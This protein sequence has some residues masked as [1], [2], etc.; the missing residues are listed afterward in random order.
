[1]KNLMLSD[2]DNKSESNSWRKS[3]VFRMPWTSDS[4]STIIRNKLS[5]GKRNKTAILMMIKLSF[6]DHTYIYTS[7]L[8]IREYWIA[9]AKEE[10]ESLAVTTPDLIIP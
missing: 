6:Y 10:T 5:R 1:M 2:R 9:T 3:D 8:K 4:Q 7:P